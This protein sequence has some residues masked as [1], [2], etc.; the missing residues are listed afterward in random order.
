MHSHNA[1]QIKKVNTQYLFERA[2]E[3]IPAN[4][5]FIFKIVA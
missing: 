2:E 1:A 4:G 5:S 3:K